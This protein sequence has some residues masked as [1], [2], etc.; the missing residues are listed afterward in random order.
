MQAPSENLG[1][2]PEPLQSFRASMEE[3]VSQNMVW[4]FLDKLTRKSKNVFKGVTC[5]KTLQIS[6]NIE[7]GEVRD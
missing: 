7:K 1:V 4:N 3:V 2:A 5:L 6:Q